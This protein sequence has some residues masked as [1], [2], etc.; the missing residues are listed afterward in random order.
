MKPRTFCWLTFAVA[1]CTV[2]P[3]AT[4]M[5]V[6]SGDEVMR[7]ANAVAAFYMQ[8]SRLDLAFKDSAD[9]GKPAKWV[10]TVA[11]TPTEDTRRR[12]LLLQDSNAWSRTNLVAGK[13]ANTDLI[14]SVGSEVTD[15]RIALLQNIAAIAKIGI[16]VAGF[17]ATVKP[18]TASFELRDPGSFQKA[19]ATK[20][21]WQDW[22]DPKIPKLVISVGPP[23]VT[24]MPYRPAL[25]QPKLNGL[26]AAACR[27]VIINYS[28]PDGSQ[29]IWRGKIADSDS[30][31]FTAMPRKGKIEYQD[32]CGTSVT[33][34]KDPTAT[35]DAV[36]AAAITQAQAVKDALD[37][38]NAANK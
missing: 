7:H 28:A 20:P 26:F 8:G 14:S 1:G 3:Q 38:Q 16:A 24:A 2:N 19:A 6:T 17:Q 15:N 23:P 13:R 29:Y 9:P 33:A 25:L 36:I 35:N 30:V 21:E 32:Q 37:K 22:S 12:F 4:Q 5:E 18:F 10:L 11:D 31:E 34:D 27:P